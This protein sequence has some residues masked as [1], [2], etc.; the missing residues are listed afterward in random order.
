MMMIS[1]RTKYP[2]RYLKPGLLCLVILLAAGLTAA[3]VQ[4]ETPRPKPGGELRI[5]SLGSTLNTDLD[6]AGSGYPLV[7]EHLY[8]GLVRLDQNLNIFPGLAD[9]WSVA[10]N[11][12]KVIFY[13]RQ[14]AFFHNGQ[15][16]TAADVKFTYE[17]LF[18]LKSRPI[19]SQFASRIEGGEE[20]WNGLAP[21]VRGLRVVD[22]KILEI[23]WKQP[24][25]PNFYF[26]AADFAKILPA[27]LVQSQKK[28]FFEKPVG[29][30][31]FRFD[32][33]LRNTR[34]DI[35]GIRLVRNENYFA[36]KPF[37]EAVEISPMFQLESFFEN[38][39]QVIPYLTFRIPRDKYQ[40]LESNLLQLSYLFY[41]CHLPP[42][43]NPEV[44][45]ALLAFLERRQLAG[46]ASSTANF[47]QVM[48]NYL[49]PFLPGLIPESIERNQ[50]LSRVLQTLEAAGLGR[51]DKP[52][53]VSIF[54]EV[55][56]RDLVPNIYQF[57]RDE[58]KPAGIKLELKPRL[59]PEELA[60]EKTPYL[61]YLD[62]R[63]DLPDPEFVLTPLFKSEAGLNRSYFHYKNRL[64]DELLEAQ[65]NSLNFDRRV[66]IFKQ[67]EK[68]LQQESPALPLFV[69][70][71]RLAYQPYLKNLKARPGDF[72]VLNLRD[73]WIDR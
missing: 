21:E 43:D 29:A 17:R 33:W 24:G 16:V 19:F 37:L 27:S 26:L 53:T 10:E 57:L 67:I 2:G 56:N 25:I 68:I 39:I 14:Q 30:G 58:L 45:R 20:F 64:L 49:P 7:I 11:G 46:L 8:E 48:D 38:E 62:W 5:R 41:S 18:R 12:R 72:M 9:Y 63:P 51:V 13:L 61:V 22:K 69:H 70:K 32:Y 15:E 66:S 44:R 71:Q 1:S 35:I 60:Q 73:V 34:L 55:A 3:P 52:L 36:R 50:N 23:E 4:E 31:P 42:F 65:K 6:P 28:K 40:I 59:S 54:F 47:C